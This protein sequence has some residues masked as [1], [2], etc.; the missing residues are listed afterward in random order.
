MEVCKTT[1]ESKTNKM[2]RNMFAPFVFINKT[3]VENC[4]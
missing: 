2:E 1:L 3:P 4:G